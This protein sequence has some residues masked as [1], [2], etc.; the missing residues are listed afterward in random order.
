MASDS[1]K[2]RNLFPILGMALR[3]PETF[4]TW[5]MAI[6]LS[7][8]TASI[9]DEASLSVGPVAVEAWHWLIVGAAMQLAL[10]YGALR[11]PKSLSTVKTHAFKRELD[12]QKIRNPVSREQ[13]IEALKYR[14]NMLDFVATTSASGAMQASLRSTLDDI[15]EWVRYMHDLALKIDHIEANEL[16]KQDLLRIPGQIREVE[17]QLANEEDE[18]LRKDLEAR[19]ER[20]Q[21]QHKNLIETERTA[22]RARISLQNTRVSLATIYA[23]MARMGTMK[24]IDG[25]RANRLREDIREEVHKLGDVLQ[26]MEEVHSGES[27]TAARSQ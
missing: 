24:S 19:R 21:L 4:L 6:A 12:P 1:S 11:N 27:Y 18:M 2:F 7:M 5:M 8:L 17:E 26:T 16:V 3:R 13:F 14:D 25:S 22:R 9:G 20:L 23:Q 10:F 15:S